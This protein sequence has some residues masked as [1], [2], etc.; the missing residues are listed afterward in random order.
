MQAKNT[1]RSFQRSCLHK[2]FCPQPDLLSGLKNQADFSAK[3]FPVLCQ[4]FCSS[5]QTGRVSIM[6]AGMHYPRSH[7]TI[8]CSAGLQDGKSIDIRPKGNDAVSLPGSPKDSH[9]TGLS[10]TR[11]RNPKTIQFLLNAPGRVKLLHTQL[12]MLMKFPPKSDQIGFFLF[13]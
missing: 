2:G 8:V 10:H 3:Q 11:V 9:H 6:P 13:K 7:G 12:R 1:L 4:Q 5:Q